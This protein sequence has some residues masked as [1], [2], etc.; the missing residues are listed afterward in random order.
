MR[1]T[2]YGRTTGKQS[3]QLFSDAWWLPRVRD[4]V[5]DDIVK[6]S[7]PFAESNRNL[8]FVVGRKI[9]VVSYMYFGAI[10]KR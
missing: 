5:C 4:R 7:G 9:G 8:I 3:N 2:T 10:R 1:F 6:C